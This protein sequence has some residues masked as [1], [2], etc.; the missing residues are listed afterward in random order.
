[1][2]KRGPYLHSFRKRACFRDRSQS[3]NSSPPLLQEKNGH[4]YGCLPFDTTAQRLQSKLVQLAV[5][6]DSSAARRERIPAEFLLVFAR[7]SSPA[8]RYLRL[9]AGPCCAQ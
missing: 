1:M 3:I 8:E 2:T 4:P 7:I 5:I 9:P 6:L